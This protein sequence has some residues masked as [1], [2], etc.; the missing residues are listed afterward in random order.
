[1]TPVK[2]VTASSTAAGAAAA[3]AAA[4]AAERGISSKSSRFFCATPEPLDD[5]RFGCSCV[6][7]QIPE[8]RF[9]EHF[10]QM[11]PA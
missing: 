10:L 11:L 1:M 5:R 4:A 2:T 7:L 6:S 8:F 9:P 3:A